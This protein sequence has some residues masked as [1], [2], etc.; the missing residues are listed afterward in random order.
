MD[1]VDLKIMFAAAQFI[2]T[3]SDISFLYFPVD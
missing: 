2:F 1:N 3:F